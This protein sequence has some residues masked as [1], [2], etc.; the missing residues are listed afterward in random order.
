MNMQE[1]MLQL[2]QRMLDIDSRLNALER[3]LTA[4][5]DCKGPDLEHQ[6]KPVRA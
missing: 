2:E 6:V 4:R 1:R 5:G 3:Q